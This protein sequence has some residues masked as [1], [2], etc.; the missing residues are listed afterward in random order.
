MG[1]HSAFGGRALSRE[2][3][4]MNK[5]TT[6]RVAAAVIAASAL[7]VLPA[8]GQGRGEGRQGQGGGGGRAAQT[9]PEAPPI[10][11]F[12]SYRIAADKTDPSHLPIIGAWR[13]DYD[14]S[15]PSVKAAGRFKD[16]GTNIYTAVDGGIR[17]ETFL[18]WPPTKVDYKTTFTDDAREYWFKLDGQNIYKDP[19][20]PNGLGQTLAVFLIDRNTLYR[21]R[22]TK[23]VI[24]ERVLYRVSPDGNTL[25]WSGVSEAGN[26]SLTVW[27]RIPLSAVGR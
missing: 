21:Q 12:G 8:L 19:Q 13:I 11:F 14:R 16:T 6:Y 18:Y 20:G 3:M 24:D 23:G 25:A 4:K 27:K 1:S 22:M 15:D 9:F 2:E 5:R 7:Y 26:G 10:G 17:A